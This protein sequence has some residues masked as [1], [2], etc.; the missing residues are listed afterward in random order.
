MLCWKGT[1]C[2]A[3]IGEES[4][5]GNRGFSERGNSRAV[6]LSGNEAVRHHLRQGPD[7]VCDTLTGHGVIAPLA[8]GS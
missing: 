6:S 4:S 8:S 3:D 7:S 1:R 2:R 5:A